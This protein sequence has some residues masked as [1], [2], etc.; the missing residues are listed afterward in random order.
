MGSYVRNTGLWLFL[1]I[2]LFKTPFLPFTFCQFSSAL[3][4]LK[5]STS[6]SRVNLHNWS[7]YYYASPESFNSF[8]P[9]FSY[10]LQWTSLWVTGFWMFF[11]K[12]RKTAIWVSFHRYLLILLACH[13]NEYGFRALFPQISLLYMPKWKNHSRNSSWCLLLL[14]CM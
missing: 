2:C 12:Y 7:G 10:L 9:L 4:Y 6:F 11:V 1:E 5:T 14:I 8:A 13:L 3:V